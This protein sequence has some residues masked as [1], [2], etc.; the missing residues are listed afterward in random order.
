VNGRATFPHAAGSPPRCEAAYQNRAT[1]SSTVATAV[2]APTVEAEV[3]PKR[4]SRKK[5]AD[6][7]TVE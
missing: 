6:P 5:I 4:R 7:F 1:A 2:E 3:K